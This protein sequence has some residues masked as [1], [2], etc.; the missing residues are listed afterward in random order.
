MTPHAYAQPHLL[1]H[2]LADLAVTAL[3]DEATLSPKPGLVDRRGS[4]AHHDLDLGL[5]LASARSLWPTFAAMACAAAKHGAID[6]VLRARLG[7]LGRTGEDHMLRTTGGINTHRGAIWAMGLL[8][9]SSALDST[10][11]AEQIASRAGAIARITDPCA[12]DTRNSHGLIASRRYGVGGAREQAQAGFPEVI[13]QGLPQ[14]IAS[15][16]A[17][18]SEPHAQLNALLAIMAHLTDTCVLHRGGAAALERTQTGARQV[19]AA[20]GVATFTGR[21]ELQRLDRAL[22]ALNASPGGAADLLAATL[23]LD[24]LTRTPLAIRS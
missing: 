20:G 3:V 5:M 6:G 7:E 22:L 8:I 16:R 14:L 1:E 17:G 4:G 21:R 11:S 15:R 10:A 2:A 13:E 24:A 18:C 19:L 23:F 12:P 9:A